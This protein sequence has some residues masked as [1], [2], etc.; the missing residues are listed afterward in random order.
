MAF[1][2]YQTVRNIGIGVLGAGAIA[3]IVAVAS[4]GS[5]APVSAPTPAPVSAPTPTPTPAPISAA[6][7]PASGALDD[8]AIAA[9]ADQPASPGEKIKDAFKGNPTKVNLYEE[10]QDRSYDR[11]KID[12]NRDDVW[13]RQWT[14]HATGRWQREDGLVLADGQWLQAGGTAL[15]LPDPQPATPVTPGA[16]TPTPAAEPFA[17]QLETVA[18]T[19]LEGRASGDKIKDL[20]RGNG[21]KVNLY[22]DDKDG[23]WDRAKVDYDR[24]EVDDEKLTLKAGFLERKSEKTGEIRVYEQGAWKAKP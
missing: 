8:A 11:L 20:F 17:A 5:D 18:K 1:V 21:P 6:A 12:A 9:R 23:R 2:R 4:G 16:V 7:I 15:P 10:T 19:M 24:D 3:G 13:D 14:R 22:D